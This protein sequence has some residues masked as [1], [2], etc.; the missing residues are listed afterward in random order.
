MA[1]FV[2]I[3]RSIR[4][5][6]IWNS[7]DSNDY[8]WFCDLY[9][10]AA[11]QTRQYK[12]GKRIVTLYKRQLLAS[13]NSLARR[14]KTNKKRVRR[15]I[16]QLIETGFISFFSKNN[17]SIITIEWGFDDSFGRQQ[18]VYP[19]SQTFHTPSQGQSPD[20][21]PTSER[22]SQCLNSRPESREGGYMRAT[23]QAGGSSMT[24]QNLHMHPSAQEDSAGVS[25]VAGVNENTSIV[26]NYIKDYLRDYLEPH[27][28]DYLDGCLKGTIEKIVSSFNSSNYRQS[29]I[30]FYTNDNGQ[31]THLRD[32]LGT[33]LSPTSEPSEGLPKDNNNNKNNINHSINHAHTRENEILSEEEHFASQLKDNTKWLQDIQKEFG[34]ADGEKVLNK[35]TLFMETQRKK[36]HLSGDKDEN[37]WNRGADY[38]FMNFQNHFRN[39]LRNELL[40]KYT[41]FKDV[42]AK[43]D[44]RKKGN[45]NTN[46]NTSKESKTIN[47]GTYRESGRYNPNIIESHTASE[48]D[49]GCSPDFLEFTRSL[50]TSAEP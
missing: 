19:E 6:W 36:A 3:D 10:S 47:Y 32:H 44:R 29:T 41:S 14:W 28:R 15:Y 11:Y 50:R 22:L 4:D 2:A 46:T 30:G 38:R 12:V 5:T 1:G 34:L 8:K 13:I 39:W 23:C 21:Y 17:I 20:L 42:K 18:N 45:S 9:M 7:D 48:Y 37:Y 24:N 35:L 16:H 40:G 43:A 25:S 31:N 26:K 33:T 49:A 27:L